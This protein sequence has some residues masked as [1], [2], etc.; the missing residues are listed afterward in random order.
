MHLN[1]LT[2]PKS[3]DTWYSAIKKLIDLRYAGASITS[4]AKIPYFE[5]VLPGL[6]GTF[7]V[8]GTNRA[9]TATQA[10]YRRVAMSSVGGR[11]TTDYTFVQ[12][13]WDDGLGFGNN[14]FFHPQYAAFVALQA[15]GLPTITRCK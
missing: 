5:N 7:N 3:G 13:L 12:L 1:N 8:L 15:S 6:A 4:V 9:L 10:A 11:N 2:D 14:L